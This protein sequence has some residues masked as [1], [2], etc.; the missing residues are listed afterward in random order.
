MPEFISPKTGNVVSRKVATGF[1]RHLF[2][3]PKFILRDEVPNSSEIQQMMDI[4]LHFL[5]LHFG[6][7]NYGARGFLKMLF[8]KL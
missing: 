3:I 1:E 5:N 4:N 6:Q 7:K 2:L 8:A